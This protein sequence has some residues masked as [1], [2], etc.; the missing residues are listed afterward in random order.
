MSV[1]EQIRSN[2]DVHG[3]EWTI[4]WATRKKINRDTVSFVIY[5][6]YGLV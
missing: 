6:K 4:D 1:A 2:I 5:G 3:F